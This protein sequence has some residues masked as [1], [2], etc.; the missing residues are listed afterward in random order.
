MIP[1]RAE[2]ASHWEFDTL[3]SILIRQF[4]RLLADQGV[5]LNED[6]IRQIGQDIAQ[7]HPLNEQAI[8][9]RD[10]LP[11][12]IQDS[13]DV[14]AGWDLT[15]AQSLKTEMTDMPGWETTADFLDV[16]NEKI[17][18]EVRIS[19]GASL[20]TALGDRRYAGFLLQAIE[21]DLQTTGRLDVDAV[22]ARRTL[23][24]AA[25]IAEDDATW[26]EQA[27]AWVG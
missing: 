20:L 7:H 10:A 21:H 8:A 13:V 12:L 22:I 18:A 5:A 2:N 14:L 6:M 11:A 3:I 16:A 25:G 19:A 17:N 1:D 15:F 23:L 24:Y 9:I 4:K 27:R 26:L